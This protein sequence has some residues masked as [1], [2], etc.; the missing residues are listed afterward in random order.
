MRKLPHRARVALSSV[1][2]LAVAL[3]WSGTAAAQ[4]ED[5]SVLSETESESEDNQIIVTGTLLRGIAPVGTNVVSVSEEEV[6]A[7][8]ATSTNDLLATIPQ[9]ANFNTIPNGGA[10]FGQ[11]I[12]QTNLRGLG[13]S[14]GTTTLTLMNGHRVVGQGILQTYVD[15]QIIPPGIIERVEVI[16]DGGSSIYG[17]DAIGGVINFITKKRFD[18]IEAVARYGFA[19]GYDTVDLNVTAGT[20]WDTGGASV[21]YAYVWHNEI[22]GIERDYVT[23]DHRGFGGNDNRSFNCTPGNIQVDHDGN[24]ATPRIT[25]PMP[26]FAGAP[27]RCD[28]SD[29]ASIYPRESRHAVFAT[30]DQDIGD[31]ISTNVTAYYAR[32]DTENIGTTLTGNGAI[33]NTN[34]YFI[35]GPTGGRPAT[36]SRSI[37]RRSSVIP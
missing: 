12:V 9:I 4:D 14:G 26:S 29:F 37:S 17:S 36:T 33:N 28:A 27:N 11:P 22:L 8:G 20:N 32:R 6:V 13:A 1:S 30:L 21:S 2:A 19:D 10:N 24:P 5:S 31:N 15:P 34:P 35:P 23:Q 3:T 16:P 25:Y 18:G 7:T